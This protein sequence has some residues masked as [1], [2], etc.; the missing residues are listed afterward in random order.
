LLEK[1]Y[2][3]FGRKKKTP[4]AQKAHKLA[5]ARQASSQRNNAE[6]TKL[7]AKLEHQASG[8]L[9]NFGTTAGFRG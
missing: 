2:F 3:S 5:G 1:K 4:V 6:P 7:I 8:A 9:Y